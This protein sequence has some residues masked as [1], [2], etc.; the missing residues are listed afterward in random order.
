VD[1]KQD[2]FKVKVDTKYGKYVKLG[3]AMLTTFG[4]IGTGAH[5]A[6]FFDIEAEPTFLNYSSWLY[7]YLFGLC[8][9]AK[10][11]SNYNYNTYQN[12]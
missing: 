4:L 12:Q 6:G 11:K 8:R 3:I 7:L 5:Q 2:E 9:L 1:K 10:N